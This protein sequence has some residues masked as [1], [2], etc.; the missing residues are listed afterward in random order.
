MIGVWT[1]NDDGGVVL[2]GRVGWGLRECV[3]GGGG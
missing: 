2:T 1:E 3:A